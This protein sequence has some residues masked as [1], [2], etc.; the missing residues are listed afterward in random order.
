M[1]TNSAAEVQQKPCLGGISVFL[2]LRLRACTAHGNHET[3]EC[4]GLITTGNAAENSFPIRA[5]PIFML[6]WQ[7]LRLAVQLCRYVMEDARATHPSSVTLQ[8]TCHAL[9][10]PLQFFALNL[11]AFG[12]LVRILP[13]IYLEQP[14]SDFHGLVEPR[15]FSKFGCFLF[16]K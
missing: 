16:S 3:A 9:G 10:C 15:E 4:P 13:N 12:S 1:I 14:S 6:L 7:L 2:E 5:F 11:G 8:Y